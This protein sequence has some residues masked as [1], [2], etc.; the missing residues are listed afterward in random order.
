MLHSTDDC[1]YLHHV[2][3]KCGSAVV[4]RA[5]VENRVL[6]QRDEGRAF[7]GIQVPSK[8]QWDFSRESKWRS[9]WNSFWTL[10]LPLGAYIHHQVPTPFY[11]LCLA[12]TG[13]RKEEFGCFG[14][15]VWH[16]NNPNLRA[17]NAAEVHSQVWEI[18]SAKQW[19]TQ[20]SHSSYRV[21]PKPQPGKK[22][23]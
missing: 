2:H 20:R 1:T 12:H 22:S 5:E 6:E 3:V 18:S 9:K 17:A 19:L 23:H 13:V 4:H 21:S 8:H 16:L 7:Q 10:K 14:A 15:L 11:A